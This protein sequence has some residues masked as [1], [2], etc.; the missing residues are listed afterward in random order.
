MAW[1]EATLTD[2]PVANPEHFCDLSNFDGGMTD[3]IH[4]IRFKDYLDC[5]E[6]YRRK[7]CK[8]IGKIGQ[9]VE[10]V[11][12]SRVHCSDNIC[13]CGLVKRENCCFAICGN[14]EGCAFVDE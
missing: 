12:E 7:Y 5:E 2:T 4:N 10:Y 3:G 13:R 11:R 8:K 6:V 9:L 1:A 14:K